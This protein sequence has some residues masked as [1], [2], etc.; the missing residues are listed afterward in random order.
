MTSLTPTH[1]RDTDDYRY[2]LVRKKQNGEHYGQCDVCGQP[3]STIHHQIE[4]RRYTKSNGIS[5]GWTTQDCSDAFGHLDCLS[6]L[7]RFT[8]TGP[9]FETGMTVRTE[10]GRAHTIV[11]MGTLISMD[12][13]LIREVTP[14]LVGHEPYET[15]V[16]LADLKDV[17]G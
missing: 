15:W 6:G 17:R 16:P 4:Q 5:D 9:T 2:Q 11:R 3:A 8:T 7:R 10:K 13:A 12:A 14:R 1:M